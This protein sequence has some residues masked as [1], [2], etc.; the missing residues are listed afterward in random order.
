MVKKM[1]FMKTVKAGKDH[2]SGSRHLRRQQE[3]IER[4]M[5][6]KSVPEAAKILRRL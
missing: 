6:A 2:Q 1:N 4:A 3:A 5:K